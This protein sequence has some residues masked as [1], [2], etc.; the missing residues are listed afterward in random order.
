MFQYQWPWNTNSEFRNGAF[1]TISINKDA[2]NHQKIPALQGN[3]EGEQYLLSSSHQAAATPYSEHWGKTRD[4][5]PNSWDAY[6]RNDSS[7]PRLLPLPIHRKGES[8][9][10]LVFF[11]SQK[12]FLMF[13]LPALCFKL[14]CNLTLCAP[15]LPP[16]PWSSS[17]RVIWDAVSWAWS[18][19]NFHWIKHTSQL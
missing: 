18:P 17:L 15:H 4:I 16:P 13:R 11:T 1:P 19:K 14:L 2:A 12:Y 10:Y 6:E 5:G 3:Q 9:K 8:A 7:E